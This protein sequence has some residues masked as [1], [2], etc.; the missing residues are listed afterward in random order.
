MNNLTSACHTTLLFLR[1]IHST[2]NFY[3]VLFWI[4]LSFRSGLKEAPDL[5]KAHGPSTSSQRMVEHASFLV[6]ISRAGLVPYS[7]VK[8]KA[9]PPFA[10]VGRLECTLE[11]SKEVLFSCT[12]PPLM[13]WR[14][15]LGI[16]NK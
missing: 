16:P 9:H 5:L 6:C 11:P 12:A 10:D 14:T 3:Y 4:S 1:R 2:V 15:V 8:E 7:P 13:T